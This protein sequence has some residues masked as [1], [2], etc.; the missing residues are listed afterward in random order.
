[1]AYNNDNAQAFRTRYR[2]AI[3]PLYNPWLHAGFV[4][5]YGL[6][7]LTLLWRTLDDRE[8]RSGGR[9]D[10]I[11]QLIQN[12]LPPAD[13][14]IAEIGCHSIMP[15]RHTSEDSSSSLLRNLSRMTPA[16]TG[17]CRSRRASA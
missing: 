2:D 8:E 4:L 5:A 16:S 1:M 6:T 13:A 3:H 7:C 14:P 12:A 10:T 11:G 15:S 17:P 9:F